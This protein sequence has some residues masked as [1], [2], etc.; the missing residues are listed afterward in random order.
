MLEDKWLSKQLGIKSFFLKNNL[1]YNLKKIKKLKSKIIFFVTCKVGI[2]S[3][4]NQL[5]IK[6]KFSLIEQSIVFKKEIIIKKKKFNF[7]RPANRKDQNQVLQIASKAFTNSR[8]FKDKNIS[9][10]KAIKIKKSWVKNYFLGKRADEMYV[11]FQK[12]KITGFVLLIKKP[13]L[14]IDLIAIKKKFQK[15]NIGSN[16]ID[17]CCNKNYN[18]NYLYAGTQKSNIESIK[19]YKK[20]NFKIDKKLNIYHGFFNSKK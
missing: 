16:L 7:I 6:N 11:S 9:K 2:K 15:K 1:S 13:K 17:Y 5:L 20:N 3:K 18:F 8:F 12:K 14:I 4:Y 10:K 19:F